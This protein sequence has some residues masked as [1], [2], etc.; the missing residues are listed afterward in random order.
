MIKLMLRD[1]VEHVI[2]IVPL[3]GN[4]L[5]EA[6]VRKTCYRAHQRIV[7][8]FC[9]RQRFAPFGLRRPGGWWK[10]LITFELALVAVKSA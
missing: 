3:P 8:L 6:L 10:V 9:P 5:M 2:E 1:S 4:N 7:G